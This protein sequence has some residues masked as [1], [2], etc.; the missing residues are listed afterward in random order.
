[1]RAGRRQARHAGTAARRLADAPAHGAALGPVPGR[2]GAGGTGALVVAG[3]A[4]R[5][6][7]PAGVRAGAVRPP[8]LGA[9]LVGHDRAAQADRARAWRGADREPQGPDLAARPAP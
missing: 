9:V 5:A 7:R 8:A 3:A 1:G 2:A 4:A 6:R